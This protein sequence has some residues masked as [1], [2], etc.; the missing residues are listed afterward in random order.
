MVLKKVTV[1]GAGP[2]GLMAAHAAETAGYPVQILSQRKKSP[3]GGA[4]YVH[5]Q[6]PDL[7][8]KEPDGEVTFEYRG[9]RAGYAHKVY[10]DPQADVSW[11]SFAG[12]VLIWNMRKVYNE[13]WDRF[14]QRVEHRTLLAQDIIH[15]QDPDAL[16]I[17]TVPRPVLC[18][19]PAFHVFKSQQVWIGYVQGP[20]QDNTIIYNGLPEVPWYRHSN[21]FSWESTEYPAEYMRQL[22]AK[23]PVQH[24]LIPVQKPLKSNCDCLPG[25][26][27]MGR[28][29]KWK[30]GVLTHHVYWDTVA[31]LARI[32][33]GGDHGEV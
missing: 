5:T 29:G 27:K 17:S 30:K 25:I 2:S 31:M 16:V 6:I 32:E 33:Q 22:I 14:E 28:Y 8:D 11:G 4:Q 19:K 15:L 10:L 13:L 1:L 26:A 12:K 3:I 9:S 24:D 18:W 23:E 20:P 21:L 7:T